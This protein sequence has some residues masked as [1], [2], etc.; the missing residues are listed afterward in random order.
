[1]KLRA[2]LLLLALLA[3]P[4]AVHGD[5]VHLKNGGRI[6]GEITVEGTKIRVRSLRGETTIAADQIDR[7]DRD[8]EDPYEVWCRLEEEAKAAATPEAWLA[9]AD[10]AARH[11]APRY[12]RAAVEGAVAA[13][14]D[15]ADA[16]RVATLAA[17]YADALRDEALPLWRRVLLLDPEHAAARRALGYHR[18]DGRWVTEDEFQAAQGNV[19]FEGAWMPSVERDRILRER[20][21]RF[22]ERE[23]ALIL[24]ERRLADR[25][26][27]L[28]REKRRLIGAEERLEAWR[29]DLERQRHDLDRREADVERRET[30][31]R[32]FHS[33]RACGGWYRGVHLCPLQLHRCGICGGYFHHGHRH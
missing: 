31:L 24:Q 16:E 20:A 18:L 6:E 28:D 7:I 30:F 23:K 4:P 13:L 5:V 15:D 3:A 22:E 27:D 11:S 29:R 14:P 19:K 12:I 32:A 8:H 9:A 2:T 25:E 1:M 21:A 10:H 33:C 17:A 26:R